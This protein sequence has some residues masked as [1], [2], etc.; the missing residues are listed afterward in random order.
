[1]GIEDV[2]ELEDE[3]EESEDVE[4][5]EDVEVEDDDDE[6]D[7][8]DASDSDSLSSSTFLTG[9]LTTRGLTAT[10]AFFL[11]TGTS[12]IGASDLF[13]FRSCD[14]AEKHA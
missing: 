8:V 5:V 13:R 12:S 7:E 3:L 14:S 9:G 6:E 10:T 1:M 2:D 11:A 4:D